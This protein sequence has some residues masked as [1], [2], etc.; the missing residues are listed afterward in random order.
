MVELEGETSSESFDA[1]ERE[2]RA[3]SL[4]T[5]PLLSYRL[6]PA[7]AP[8]LGEIL[9]IGRFLAF[10]TVTDTAGD[11]S[12][13]SPFSGDT[14]ATPTAVIAE[15]DG[16]FEVTEELDFVDSDAKG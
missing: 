5:G 11:P 6:C 1:K 16:V 13:A 10:G 14:S 8:N 9:M 12:L 2:K 4:S 3:A 7:T 15:T